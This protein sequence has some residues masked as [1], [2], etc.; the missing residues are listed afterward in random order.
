[1]KIL[2]L[3]NLDDKYAYQ[4]DNWIAN[5][6]E[7]D[8]HKVIR[9]NIEYNEKLNEEADIIIRR[10]TWK[11]DGKI[12]EYQKEVEKVTQRLKY[13]N[14]LKVNF[15]GRF[16]AKGKE[17][18]VEL[19]K[20]GY[21][22]IPTIQDK[23]DVE[24]LPECEKYLLKPLDS[25][26]GIGQLK[27]TKQELNKIINKKYIIQPI[28]EFQSEVQFYF[29]NYEFQYAL[30]FIPSKIPVYPDPVEYKYNEE[31]L[32]LAKSFAN[33]NDKLI[34]VQRIDF[35]KT[36]ENKL[37]LLEI[38]DAAPYLDL[39]M[40]KEEKRKQFITNYKKMIYNFY[41]TN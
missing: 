28:M 31:E 18:L 19:Y 33:L 16:D 10:N 30:E 15:N 3:T 27:V 41:T 39:D 22:V 8:G 5:S 6:L 1:M 11:E 9:A 40:L 4:E 34:G 32:K 13:I 37:L 29:I 26:D 2:M 38:E 14:K 17:Y 12:Q 20:K 35:I 24:K 25:Y 23:K 7:E 21:S 36:K